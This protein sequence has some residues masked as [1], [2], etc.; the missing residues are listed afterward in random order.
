[1]GYVNSLLVVL[2]SEAGH[3]DRALPAEMNF[4][5]DMSAKINFA[6]LCHAAST[7]AMAPDSCV[8][9]QYVIS[10]P[11]P[12]LHVSMM[13]C[14]HLICGILGQPWPCG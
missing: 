2:L 10:R 3:T 6:K 13:R 1:M 5:Q 7:L 11:L 12:L 14:Q 4:G 9:A 8:S